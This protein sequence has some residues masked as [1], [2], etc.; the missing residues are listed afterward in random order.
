MTDQSFCLQKIGEN[1]P[2][3]QVI[4]DL[5][6]ALASEKRALLKAPPGAGKTTFVPLALL[7]QPWLNGKKI[8]M[9]E[10][11]RLA[12]KACAVHMAGMIG[13][14]TGQTVGYQIRMDRCIGPA[15]RIEV[16]TEGILTR[17]I[18]S[19]PSLEKVGLVIFDE[20]HERHIH[21]D[22]G[23]ALCLDGAQVFN[24][25]LRILI[26][27]ATM[28]TKA[29]SMLMDNAPTIISQGKTHPVITHYLPPKAANR[30]RVNF[31][32]NQNQD[33][34]R[35]IRPA[36]LSAV[37][38]A[39]A[40]E[41]G[42]ILVFLPGI[43]EIRDLVKDLTHQIVSDRSGSKLAI[44]P[45]YGNL[46]RTDQA[47]A[48][49]P[50]LPGRR[51]I[52]L[53]TSIAETSLTIEGVTIVVDTGLM[54]V[55]RFS[56]GTG[57]GQL[58]TI[59]VSLAS[60]D[61]RRGRAGRTAPGVCYRI[62]SQYQTR[63]LIPF[64]RPEIL[65]A[66]LTSLVLELAQWGVLDPKTLKWLDLPPE[67]AFDRAK[68]LLIQLKGLDAH[69]H[70]TT[71]GRRLL[72][73]GIHPRLAHM[74][75]RADRMGQGVLACRLAALLGERDILFFKEGEYDP[76]IRLRLDVLAALSSG[77]SFKKKGGG[78]QNVPIKLLDT[79]FN[80]PLART[81]LKNVDKMGKDLKINFRGTDMELSGSVLAFAWP[82]RVA[83]KRNNKDL[84]FLMASGSGA[85]FKSVNCLSHLPY[86][87][88]VHLDGNPRNAG[89]FLAAPYS[90]KDLEY[91]FKDQIEIFEQFFWDKH[92][93]SVR[94]VSKTTYGKLV[95][96]EAIIANPDPA[97]VRSCLIQGIRGEDL[98]ILPWTKK[99]RQLQNRAVFL[100][101]SGYFMDLPDLSD[102]NLSDNLHQWL[103]PFL[104]NIHSAAGLKQVDLA[105]ALTS[106]LT[107]DQQ[108]I[109]HTNAP[110]HV[111]LPSGSRVALQYMGDSG[112]LESPVLAVRLQEVFGLVKSPG[113]AGGRIPITFHLLSPAG[114]PVQITRDLDSFWKNTYMAVKKDLMGRY[115]KHYW[116]EDPLSAQA[117]NRVK[118][119]RKKG[120]R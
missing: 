91:D 57:M 107:W 13:E 76:D 36:C 42:D 114:R 99:L 40:E 47:T 84:S 43:R 35:S 46:S 92:S 34:Y 11:R 68:T 3:G 50:S 51:K 45:L 71:H 119:G 79:G 82:E 113:I 5:V 86:I 83:R 87:V 120:V 32:S 6:L 95:L 94:C 90:K 72:S 12:A 27:S 60:A 37:E 18:Q 64:N 63:G 105:A 58:D 28:D 54:R 115:P 52:V 53:A 24:Q 39:L 17:R 96:G 25:E 44:L 100:K 1:L 103:G 102:T 98:D 38:K 75:L 59:F 8:I 4:P 88:A 104:D 78:S 85:F 2:V 7:D 22:L 65:S 56:P 66:D 19:D 101:K 10:P 26:M 110:T 74:I 30:S 73:A 15:T 69:G 29:L 116:P 21:S 33:W 61:Q 14:K 70:I 20:F 55:P 49:A 109:I 48:I 97:A 108:Q 89:I 31:Y 93:R 112:L 118:P 67:I 81:I 41:S 80:E 111:T 106:L 9:L 23:L 16:I 117:T 77:R 62:W